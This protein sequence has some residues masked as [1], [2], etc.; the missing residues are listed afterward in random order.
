MN[1]LCEECQGGGCKW[2]DNT[3]L[4]HELRYHPQDK[5]KYSVKDIEE[6]KTSQKVVGHLA[7]KE[8]KAGVGDI[9]PRADARDIMN[10]TPRGR[11]MQ[12]NVE[13]PTTRG[14]TPQE[15]MVYEPTFAGVPLAGA[16]KKMVNPAGEIFRR[17]SPMELAWTLLKGD[18]E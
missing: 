9:D 13:I 18:L 5:N 14:K 7:G 12:T 17:S 6:G 10:D 15:G 8:G 4:A 16:G 11:I 2:C 1:E 3:G